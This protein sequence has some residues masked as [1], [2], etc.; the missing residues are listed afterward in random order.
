MLDFVAMV[1]ESD[2]ADIACPLTIYSLL[3]KI[4]ALRPSTEIDMSNLLWL[5]G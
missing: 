5:H 1:L 3:V 2:I 4:E